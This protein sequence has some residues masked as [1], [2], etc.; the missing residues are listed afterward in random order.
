MNSSLYSGMDAL[1]HVPPRKPPIQPADVTNRKE[2]ADAIWEA[3]ARACRAQTRLG[4]SRQDR[5]EQIPGWSC[6]AY[7]AAQITL[8]I[9][10]RS[11]P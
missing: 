4:P 1:G 8:A 9:T 2:L 10:P 6:D 7:A 3:I 11:K 5:V